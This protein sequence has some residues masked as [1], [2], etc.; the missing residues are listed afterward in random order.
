MPDFKIAYGWTRQDPPY[1]VDEE[2]LN[3]SPPLW[4]ALL[5]FM[6][7]YRGTFTLCFPGA[8]IEL[9]FDH[10]LSQTFEALPEWL[11]EIATSPGRE[12]ELLFASQGTELKLVAVRDGEQVSLR[13]VSLTPG[14]TSKDSDAPDLFAAERFLQQWTRFLNAV[15]DALEEF[16]PTL[17]ADP[18]FREYRRKLE[19]ISA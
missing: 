14:A 7:Q 19:V 10:D 8:E 12:A 6:G 13:V 5:R 3:D 2:R 18:E 16:E 17:V 9:W 1:E 11:K 4:R 15:L